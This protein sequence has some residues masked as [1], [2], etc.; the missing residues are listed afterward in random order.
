VARESVVRV[1]DE[2]EMIDIFDTE[3]MELLL[4]RAEG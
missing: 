3:R 2:E 4:Q 1:L